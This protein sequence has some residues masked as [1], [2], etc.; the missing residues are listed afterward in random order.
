MKKLTEQDRAILKLFSPGFGGT[1]VPDWLKRYLENGLGGVTLFGSN[2]PD[3]E[4]ASNLIKELRKYNSEIVISIDEEGGDVTRIFA[5]NGSPIP[6]AALLGQIDDLDFT[7]QSFFNLG[8]Y[9]A[10]LDIDLALAPVA[11]L[12][13]NSKNPIVGVRSFGSN[14][15][16]VSKHVV[17][18][19]KGFQ[20]AGISACA[21]HFPG[22]GGALE[23]SHLSLPKISCSYEE[24]FNTHLQPFNAAIEAKVD[25]LM[26]GHLL[27]ETIDNQHSASL[28]KNVMQ[29]LLRKKLKFKGTIITDALDMG[30]VGGA[31][32]ISKSARLAILNGADFLC[33]SGLADQSVFINESLVELNLAI[34]KGLISIDQLIESGNR[35]N[36]LRK[37]KDKKTSI[38]KLDVNKIKSGFFAKGHISFKSN[39]IRYSKIQSAPTI[40]A[41]HINWGFK[42][43]TNYKKTYFQEVD[44]NSNP[45]LVIFRDAWRNKDI[46]NVLLT[47]QENNPDCIFI[48]MGW[49][50][51]E[52]SP[53][54]LIRTFGVGE[55]VNQAVLEMVLN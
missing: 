49:P 24:L 36:L 19:L 7:T 43:L 10:H 12:V 54:N 13:V 34:N 47:F 52:F 31:S 33:F 4:R 30:A 38:T 39:Q 2:V 26:V 8:L 53:K 14:P 28:S 23:D 35:I 22:H 21:K 55:V 25:S 15:E 37:E 46:L 32:Y 41:G 29:D 9:L 27:V 44:L 50:T 3:L 6:S 1:N 20:N 16:S 42:N 5:N 45:D 48:D 17:A 11:D 51:E 40:A 18:A